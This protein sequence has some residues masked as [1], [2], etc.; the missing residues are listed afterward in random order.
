M[1]AFVPLFNDCPSY[2]H[3]DYYSIPRVHNSMGKFCLAKWSE[4]KYSNIAHEMKWDPI[5]HEVKRLTLKAISYM[6]ALQAK[7]TS[8]LTSDK[9]RIVGKKIAVGRERK[10]R[11]RWIEE[12]VTL[13]QC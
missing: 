13:V 2:K 11:V 7:Q 9:E 1:R 6:L 3:Y 10:S 5:A 8:I 4:I 12:N